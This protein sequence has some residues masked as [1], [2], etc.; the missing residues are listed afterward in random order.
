MT[1]KIALLLDD[2]FL[3][4]WERQAVCHLIEK[5]DLDIVVS[6]VIVNDTATTSSFGSRLATFVRDFSLWHCVVAVRIVRATLGQ[7]AWYRQRIALQ[8]VLDLSTVNVRHCTPEPAPDVGNR[9]PDTIVSDL[10]EVDIAIRFGFGILKGDALEAPTHGVLSY[11]HGDLT[12]YRGRPSGFYEFIHGRNSTG[13]TVQRL[14]EELDAGA[15]AASTR[16][17]ISDADSLRAVHSRQFRAS[18]PLL[19]EAVH[20]VAKSNSLRVPD[21]L[22]PLYTKPG[23]TAVLSYMWRRLRMSNI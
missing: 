6:L 12:E 22:G 8:S 3:K 17:D 10:S 18:P 9:L 2:M 11:H 21:T 20:N 16:C 13:I 19:C 15:I 4:E 7:P 1:L 23:W 14:S 5:C